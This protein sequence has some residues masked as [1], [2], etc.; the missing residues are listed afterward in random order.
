MIYNIVYITSLIHISALASLFVEAAEVDISVIYQTAVLFPPRVTAF[1]TLVHGV[2]TC[3]LNLSF[4]KI[5]YVNVNIKYLL[6]KLS[7]HLCLLACLN[8]LDNLITFSTHINS[9]NRF[10]SE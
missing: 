2:Y 3:V 5:E 6:H 1:C 4:C 9:T 7:C 8:D 10:L